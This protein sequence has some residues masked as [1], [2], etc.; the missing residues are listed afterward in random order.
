MLFEHNVTCETHDRCKSAHI[1]K[2]CIR[3]WY[4]S[5][6]QNEVVKIN[7]T[8]KKY[9]VKKERKMIL[10]DQKDIKKYIDKD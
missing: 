2:P 8:L 7:I 10:M 4:F 3:L 5:K 1:S 6:C 9:F